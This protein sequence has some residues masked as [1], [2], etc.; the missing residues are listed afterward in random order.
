M[1]IQLEQIKVNPIHDQIYT[2]NDIEDLKISMEKYGLLEPIIVSP[3]Y[4]IISGHRRYLTAKSL[5]WEDIEVIEK[6]VVQDEMEYLIISANQHRHKKT[7]ETINEINRLYDYYGRHRGQRNDLTLGHANQSYQ[8]HTREKIAKLLGI[9]P[10]GITKLL[11]IQKNNPEFL[12]LIDKGEMTINFAN[13]LTNRIKKLTTD[14]KVISDFE[15]DHSMNDNCKIFNKS[16]HD[17][18][19][20]PDG[21][22]QCI[23]TSPPFFFKRSYGNGIDEIGLEKTPE[24]YI[25]RVVGHLTDC[26]RVLKTEGSFFLNLGDTFVNGSLQSIPHRIIL[27]L[28]NDGWII[29]NTI[30]WQKINPYPTA[31]TNNLTPSY[32]FVFHLVKD[33]NYY[34]DPVRVPNI[35][36]KR[37]SYPFHKDTTGKPPK[38][39]SPYYPVMDNKKLNDFWNDDVIKTVVAQQH[40][41]DFL[42][43]VEHP[44]PFPAELVILPVLMTT[45]PGDWVLDNFLG[46]GTTGVVSLGLNRRFVGYDINHDFCK[47]A[48]TRL[49]QFKKLIL[50]EKAA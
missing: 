8:T 47:I 43:N 45:K 36:E 15:L 22:I 21:S 19:E 35:Y 1:K 9:S 25:E 3:E 39:I 38:T 34:Y 13:R 40:F 31:T 17:M 42:K 5:E 33:L 28:M 20:L 12:S 7:I 37:V 10:T 46:S 16:S 27:L 48:A 6:N 4:I 49:S 14:K 23:F 29:R 18:S 11:N 24:E 32:E 2:S 41:G 26:W 50:K 30:I 44:A